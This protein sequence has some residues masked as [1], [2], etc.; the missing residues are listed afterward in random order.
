MSILIG[1][2]AVFTGIDGSQR[3]GVS[4]HAKNGDVP[5]PSIEPGGKMRTSRDC[6][7]GVGGAQKEKRAR[8]FGMFQFRRP[9]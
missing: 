4:V 7:D 8:C 1:T 3:N 6:G 5:S 9:L 2:Y